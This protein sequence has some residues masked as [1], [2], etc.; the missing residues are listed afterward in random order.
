LEPFLLFSPG[1]LGELSLE[2]MLSKVKASSSLP[3]ALD[4]IP[5]IAVLSSRAKRRTSE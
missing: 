5:A 2:E 4:D 1:I 3:V